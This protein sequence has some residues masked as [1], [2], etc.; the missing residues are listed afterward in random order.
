MKTLNKMKFIPLLLTL[1][2]VIMMAVSAI[3]MAAQT[4]VDLGT[5]SSF[6]VLAGSTITNTG[7]TTINGDAGGDVG[8]SPGTEFTGQASVSV[9]GTVY[10]ADVD[11]VASVAKDDLVT[12][13]DDAAGRTPVTRIPTELGGTT[14]TPG[15]YD[16]ADGTFQITGTLTLDAQGDPDGVFVFKTASTLITASDSNVNLINSA[17]FCR[18]FWK[19]G[20]SATLGMNSH[21]V[22]HIFALTSITAD[23]GATVQGQL[24][25]R[26]GAVTLDTN[27]I[28]NGT[29]A[30]P[31]T[32][33]VPPAPATLHVIKHVINDNGRTAVAANFN[34]HVKTSGSDV[35][36]SPAP[37][38]ESPGTTY[39]L[40]AGTYVVSEDT[41][42]GYTVSYSGDSDFSGNITLASGDNKTVTLTNNDI[43]IPPSV[44]HSS[45]GGQTTYPPLINVIKT[46]EPLALT[47]GQGSVTYTY[48]VTNPGMVALSNVSVTDD[49]VSP[50][51]YVSGDDNADNLLQANETWIYTGK[52]NLNATTTN[53]AT[54]K[55]S[56]NGITAI[57]IAFATVVVTPTVPVYP[58]LI[59]IIK[60]PEP[61]SLTS[62]QGSVTYTYKVTNPSMVA[63]SNVSVTDD[64]VSPVNYVSGDVNADNLLQP[65]ET[66]I[67]TGK[68]NLNVTTTN[69]A[70]AE[71]SANGMTAIDI[72]FATVVVTPPVVVTPTVTG[73]QLPDTSTPW[74]N[75]LLAG[76][77]LTL[78]G[79]VG[80]WITRKKFYA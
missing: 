18:I 48:K 58:P 1:L 12:A 61:L 70:R 29:C 22:G 51:N 57:D 11:G 50:V 64:K 46:P 77:A 32:P 8:L 6:A 23:S 67:Y 38:V 15:T 28:T 72:A 2:L 4:P 47:S 43:P 19:V 65:N 10:L 24:L 30:I 63:L 13:Y 17:R 66:W 35:A 26:N 75:V 40:A 74:Y 14:L 33:P 52:M 16:S 27:T 62:G 20:S 54:A 3:S 9:S 36:A 45:G 79:V 68:M 53:T 69:T 37:G 44:T 41:F 5:T 25:A 34:L 60:T 55:G 31:P 21:F 39:T 78:I 56:A 73:R 76:A 42:A 7:T 71:G 80:W 59:N 49:K